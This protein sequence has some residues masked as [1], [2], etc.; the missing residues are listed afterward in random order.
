MP[1]SR[2]PYYKPP[3]DTCSICHKS[4]YGED[5]YR[6]RLYLRA[7]PYKDLE[8]KTLVVCSTCLARLRANPTLTR[9][10]K[11]RYRKMPT[12]GRG[13]NKNPRIRRRI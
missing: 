10:L 12:L 9:L 5:R 7:E 8:Y 1:Y 2:P 13:K 3:R 11:I 4:L 6:V